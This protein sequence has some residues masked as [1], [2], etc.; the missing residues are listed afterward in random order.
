MLLLLL[1]L[2]KQ[3]GW[4]SFAWWWCRVLLLE[5]RREGKEGVLIWKTVQYRPSFPPVLGH[6]SKLPLF[7]CDVVEKQSKIKGL[8]HD[9]LLLRINRSCY[10]LEWFVITLP[11]ALQ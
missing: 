10:K 11:G 4:C 1:V 7:P 2:E 3:T 8:F 9:F 6:S 5:E